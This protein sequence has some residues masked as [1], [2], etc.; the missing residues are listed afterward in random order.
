MPTWIVNQEMVRRWLRV[1]TA[2]RV[3]NRSIPISTS[4]SKGEFAC[5]VTPVVLEL[6]CFLCRQ[7]A[8]R[9]GHVSLRVGSGAGER[10]F[11]RTHSHIQRLLQQ[12]DAAGRSQ[13]GGERPGEV[14][15]LEGRR[16]HHFEHLGIQ[17]TPAPGDFSTTRGP[18]VGVKCVILQSSID[19]LC[20][21]HMP[22]AH[23]Q[24]KD[25]KQEPKTSWWHWRRPKTSRETTP[26]TE[27]K[28]VVEAKDTAIDMGDEQIISS[29]IS[30]K[31]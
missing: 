29:E 30:G 12:S 15:Q 9:S 27:A 7:R 20:S 21:L 3:A 6:F 8:Q 28:T 14:L 16:P 5:H 4:T 22:S 13:L 19:Q 11:R 17:Q 1:L 23:S 24:D 18:S 31:K 26:A 25:S 2:R 10:P